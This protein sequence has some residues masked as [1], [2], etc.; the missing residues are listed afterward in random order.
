MP[1]AKAMQPTPP[2][3]TMAIPWD[4]L[5]TAVLQVTEGQ[6]ASAS[7]FGWTVQDFPVEGWIRISL[8]RETLG[9]P[10]T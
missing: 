10:G 3:A 8:D 5:R 2:H 7:G 1:R 4:E 9:L 6:K